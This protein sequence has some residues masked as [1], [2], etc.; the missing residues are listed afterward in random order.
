MLINR[1]NFAV[2][3]FLCTLLIGCGQSKRDDF[4]TDSAGNVGYF[5]DHR[6]RWML[7]NYWAIWC[8]PCVTEIPHINEFAH[9]NQQTVSAFSVN[10]DGKQGEQLSQQIEKLGIKFPTLNSDPASVLGYPR[11][12]VLPTTLIFDPAGKLHRT[13][14]GPQTLQDLQQAIQP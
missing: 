12:T 9:N 13:L 11:P 3:L 7:I 14:Q 8:K 2:M 5:S 10:F 6:G 1:F 4:Y